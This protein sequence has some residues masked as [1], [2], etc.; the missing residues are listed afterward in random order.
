[1][2]D[3]ELVVCEL[4]DVMRP[5]SVIICCCCCCL[6]DL[7]SSVFMF[8]A[9]LIAFCSLSTSSSSPSPLVELN[10]L[11]RR[12][13]ILL[14]ESAASDN[15]FVSYSF[16]VNLRC[17]DSRRS[18]GLTEVVVVVVDSLCSFRVFGVKYELIKCLTLLS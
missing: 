17:L 9:F 5:L 6:L 18:F 7:F 1:M 2:V 8:N 15:S 12:T 14:A 3:V 4:N 13:L 11:A 10:E 16:N